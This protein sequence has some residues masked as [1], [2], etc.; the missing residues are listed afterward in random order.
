MAKIDDIIEEAN[1]YTDYCRLIDYQAAKVQEYIDKANNAAANATNLIVAAFPYGVGPAIMAAK[2][3]AAQVIST[4]EDV[5][6]GIAIADAI[7]TKLNKLEPP[8][9]GC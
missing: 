6:E 5:V 7:T 2:L 1:Q 3:Q 4:A 9:G 8:E